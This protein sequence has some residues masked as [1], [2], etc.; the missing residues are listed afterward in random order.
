MIDSLIMIWNVTASFLLGAKLFTDK[1]DRRRKRAFHGRQATFPNGKGVLP[2][3]G[4]RC[5]LRP[6]R[7]PP[8][9]RWFI[10]RTWYTSWYMDT[11][12]LRNPV[13]GRYLGPIYDIPPAVNISRF[14]PPHLDPSLRGRYA[15]FRLPIRSFLITGTSFKNRPVICA[16]LHNGL[17]WAPRSEADLRTSCGDPLPILPCNF[18]HIKRLRWITCK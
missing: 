2:I 1:G 15:W 4:R 8:A 6:G 10:A 18:L 17:R 12:V 14:M 13:C 16:P 9:P 3:P 11:T 7:R 5:N